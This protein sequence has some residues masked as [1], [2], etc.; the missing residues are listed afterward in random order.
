MWTDIFI[1]ILSGVSR[2]MILFVVASGLTLIFGVLRIPNFAHG[3]FYMLAAFVAYAV[4]HAVGGSNLGFAASLLMAPLIL[5]VFG[6]VFEFMLL[7]RIAGRLHL[8]QLIM[9]FAMTLIIAD[10]IKMIWGGAYRSVGYPPLLSGSVEIFGRPFPT[11]YL[12]VI[13]VGLIIAGLLSL[14]MERTRFGRTVSAAVVDPEMVGALGVNVPRL[15]TLVFGLGAAL[16]GLGGALAAPVGSVSLGI[17]DSIIIE[18]FA[19]VII[20]G[21]GSIPGALAAALIIG[22]VQSLGIMVAPRLAIAFVFIALCV[23]L[24]VRPQGLLGRR[25]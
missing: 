24:L 18:S 13:A 10:G 25:V 17:G 22:V 21:S 11:Y 19:V 9:T 20:G 16:A 3:S 23:V 6:L 5:G 4:T 15:Y 12:L 14:L 8:Y 2:G 1:Q 7:R